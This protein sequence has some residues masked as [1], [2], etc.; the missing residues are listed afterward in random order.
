MNQINEQE[1]IE[2]IRA[3]YQKQQP[4]RVEKLKKLD[5]R[6]RRP[7]E[8]FAYVFGILGA[9]VLGLGMCLAMK[10]IG[11]L[12]PLGIAIGSVG[13]AMISVN[14]LIYTKIKES[15]KK[16]YSAQIIALSSALLNDIK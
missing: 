14:Y 5:N 10:V 7:A 2:Q 4:S 13:I 12:M 3:S 9:L 16:K 6:V 8:I 1:I 15:R 11:N